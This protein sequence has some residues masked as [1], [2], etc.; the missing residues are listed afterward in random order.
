MLNFGWVLFDSGKRSADL[1]QARELLA[2]TNAAQDETLQTIF[3]MAAQAYYD[4]SDAQASLEAA[5]ATESTAH[6][7]LA[8]TTARHGGG[9]GALSDQLQAETTYRRAVLDRVSAEGNVSAATGTL[10]TA[11]GLDANTHI[12]ISSTEPAVDNAAF[13]QNV[14]QLIDEAKTQ[15]PKL[16]VARARLESRT[17]RTSIQF[18]LG[19]SPLFRLWAT[20]SQIIR[21]I[22][23]NPNSFPSQVAG[24]ARLVSS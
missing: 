4:L 12:R 21:R 24:E 23:S 7:S 16:F 13:V 1:R 9:V 11:M 14:D 2:A 8:D 5:R 3:F 19:Q 18:A 6:D 10:A 15:H 22:S 17:A 20:S